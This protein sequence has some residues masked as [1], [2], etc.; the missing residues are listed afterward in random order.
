M[1]DAVSVAIN[2]G[3]EMVVTLIVEG[4]V[5]TLMMNVTTAPLVWV[6]GYGPQ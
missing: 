1:S 4:L 5:T 2:V 3:R 6:P